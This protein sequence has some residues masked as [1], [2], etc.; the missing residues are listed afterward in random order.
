MLRVIEVA[1]KLGV[2]KVTI[3]K[4]MKKIDELKPY[5]VKKQ[6]ITY[7]KEDG[8]QIIKNDLVK[9]KGIETKNILNEKWDE[10]INHLRDYKIFLENQKSIKQN[11]L[12]NK[13]KQIEK[14]K[15]LIKLN[16]RR[17]ELLKK[18]YNN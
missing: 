9:F 16:K 10:E 13:E 11:Q 17:L 18:R 8:I 1:N 15:Y 7:I 3:Y 5:I 14:I 2:S 6:K 4:K 12:N